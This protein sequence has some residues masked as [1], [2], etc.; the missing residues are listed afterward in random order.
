MFQ[1]QNQSPLSFI[2]ISGIEFNVKMVYKTM[3]IVTKTQMPII[4]NQVWRHSPVYESREENNVNQQRNDEKIRNQCTFD[5][6]VHDW[7][8]VNF[9]FI[10]ILSIDHIWNRRIYFKYKS[11]HFSLPSYVWSSLLTLIILINK[12]YFASII[13][14][15]TF[16][17]VKFM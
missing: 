8:R 17:G 10:A 5:W 9:N 6:I 4:T 1:R 15:L 11:I 16:F 3:S 13:I 12:K 14:F 2:S 7:N